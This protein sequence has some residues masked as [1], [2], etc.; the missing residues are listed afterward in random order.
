MSALRRFLCGLFG[1][2]SLP[3]TD[4]ARSICHHCPRCLRLVPGGLALVRR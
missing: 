2:A 4:P 3:G 1:H